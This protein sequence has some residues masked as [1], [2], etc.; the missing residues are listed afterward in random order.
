MDNPF[1]KNPH[2]EGQTFCNNCH[3][4]SLTEEGKC[5]KCGIQKDN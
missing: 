5:Q 1:L 3:C 4:W 2:E